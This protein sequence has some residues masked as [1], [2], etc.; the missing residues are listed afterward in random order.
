[1]PAYSTN[2]P[3]VDMGSERVLIGQRGLLGYVVAKPFV[4]GQPFEAVDSTGAP[5][6]KNKRTAKST[7]RSRSDPDRKPYDIGAG[8][9]L[10]WSIEST[11]HWQADPVTMPGWLG[12]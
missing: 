10:H 9:Q 4:T 6:G 5:I 3:G 7:A 11:G 12:E 1:M 2:A 8:V